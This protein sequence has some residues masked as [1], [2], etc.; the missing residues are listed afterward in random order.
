MI[1]KNQ[2][3]KVHVNMRNTSVLYIITV[4]MW[5]MLDMY[6]WYCLTFLLSEVREVCFLCL[7]PITKSVNKDYH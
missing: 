5:Q 1:E 7:L 3:L 6:V 2:N 4:Y